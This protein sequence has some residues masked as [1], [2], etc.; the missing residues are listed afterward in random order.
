[1][2]PILTI[3]AWC[4]DSKVKTAEA[5]A[6]GFVVSHGLCKVCAAKLDAAA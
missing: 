5:I 3:C 1:M 4:S 6:A 2:K